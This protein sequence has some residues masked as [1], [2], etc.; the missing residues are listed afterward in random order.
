MKTK[1]KDI[2]TDPERISQIE[3]GKLTSKLELKYG[4]RTQKTENRNFQMIEDN[5]SVSSDDQSAPNTQN[6]NKDI[7]FDNLLSGSDEFS[8]PGKRSRLRSR[9]K[10]RTKQ[11]IVISDDEEEENEVMEGGEKDGQAI[12]GK[13]A[14]G[15]F[16]E[17]IEDPLPKK[18]KK[19]LFKRKRKKKPNQA[20]F[21]DISSVGYE[22]GKILY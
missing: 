6:L 2:E 20:D 9:K 13:E 22:R 17:D 10:K 12:E 16:V 1:M 14:T 8:K 15:I 21:S 7:N 4:I 3:R 18:K 11:V 19:K 5:M